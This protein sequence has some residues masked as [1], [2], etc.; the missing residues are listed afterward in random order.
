MK[1]IYR[2]VITSSLLGIII[3]KMGGIRKVGELLAGMNP[4]YLLVILLI[5]TADRAL[6]TFKWLRL[7]GCKKIYIPMLTGLKIYC[8]SMIWGMFLPSTIGSDAIR[9][10]MTTQRGY[11]V[12]EI[13]ASVVIERVAGF[14]S[15]LLLGMVSCI[16]M[17]RLQTVDLRPRVEIVLWFACVVLFLGTAGFI[18]SF[19]Q[20]FFDLIHDKLFRRFKEI[21]IMKKLKSFHLSYTSYRNNKNE[22]FMFF[23]LTF[24]EQLLP[25]FI[26]W[27]IALSL[28]INVGIYVVAGAFPLA[29]LISRLPISLNGLGVFEAVFA[30]LISFAGVSTTQAVAIAF[31]GRILQTIAWLPWWLS[32]MIGRRSVKPPL[33]LAGKN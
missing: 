32:E 25:I 12:K 5:H 23:G 16:L 7:L 8:S 17:L 33:S 18:A 21:P 15:A 2:F 30:F 28:G 20:R 26:S 24:F 14:L 29:L 11:D 19:S 3:W 13:F 9:I 4:A 6:M 1:F 10:Y 27:L 22:I 31:G